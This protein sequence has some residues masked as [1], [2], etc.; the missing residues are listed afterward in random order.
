VPL[1]AFS[2]PEY[3]LGAGPLFETKT[4]GRLDRDREA[5]T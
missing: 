4:R 3:D 5:W 2:S 1:G